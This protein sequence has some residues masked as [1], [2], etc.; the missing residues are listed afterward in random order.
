MTFVSAIRMVPTVLILNTP[1]MSELTA[2]TGMQWC[3]VLWLA[4]P[5]TAIAYAVQAWGLQR[6]RSS[7]AYTTMN[8]LVPFY[9]M[10]I[11]WV[12]YGDLPSVWEVTGSVMLIMSYFLLFFCEKKATSPREL[13][14]I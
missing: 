4:I 1:V 10:V 7:T 2:M 14:V 12:M 6:V 13:V 9:A 11:R 3:S 5:G 8:S